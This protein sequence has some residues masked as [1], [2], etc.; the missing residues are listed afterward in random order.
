MSPEPDPTLAAERHDDLQSILR[1]VRGAR[2]LIGGLMLAGI[3]AVC[4]LLWNSYLKLNDVAAKSEQT[5]QAVQGVSERLDKT[6][7]K[8]TRMWYEGGWEYKRPAQP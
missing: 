3:L 2:T 6:A 1:V 7:E 4:G 8:V 5:T